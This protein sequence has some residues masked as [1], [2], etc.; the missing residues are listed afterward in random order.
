MRARKLT[1]EPPLITEEGQVVQKPAPTLTF[2]KGASDI[3]SNQQVVNVEELMGGGEGGIGGLS[4]ANYTQN[5]I[6]AISE[7]RN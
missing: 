2:K 4:N 7:L 1:G 6:A 5:S 3:L